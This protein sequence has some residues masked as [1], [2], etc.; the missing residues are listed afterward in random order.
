MMKIS[1]KT[2]S[3]DFRFGFS[4]MSGVQ[5]QANWNWSCHMATRNRQHKAE[6]RSGRFKKINNKKM[7]NITLGFPVKQTQVER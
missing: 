2:V 6:V 5:C 7:K 3:S 4:G 1:K